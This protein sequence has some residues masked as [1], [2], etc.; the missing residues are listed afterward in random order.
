MPKLVCHPAFSP[1][2]GIEVE[3]TIMRGKNDLHVDWSIRGGLST[4]RLPATAADRRRDGLWETTCFE[5][6]LRRKGDPAYF[7][8]NASP[9]GEWASYRFD[10]YRQGMRPAAA[11]PEKGLFVL[12]DEYICEVSGGFDLSADLG[13]EAADSWSVGLSAI[14]EDENGAKSYW[15]LAHPPGKPDFHHRDCFAAELAPA[16][17]L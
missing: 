15:A 6:F 5:L 7:E 16:A 17:T 3:A 13:A 9:S 14:I 11:A 10:A 2:A 8:I 4:I 12:G 1:P